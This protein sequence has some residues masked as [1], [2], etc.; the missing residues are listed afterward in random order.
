[1]LADPKDP[2]YLGALVY[3]HHAAESLSFSRAAQILN[4][5][6]SA[7]SH[8]ITA[9][10]NA[11]GKRLFERRVR[12]VRLTQDGAE[13]ARATAVI[14]NELKEITG[15]LT[16]QEVL[17]VSVG[18]YLSS[19]WLL[20]RIGAFEAQ[21]PGLRVDLIHVIGQPDVRLADV[22]ITWAQLDDPATGTTLLFNTKAVP[23]AAPGLNVGEN[24]WE[25]KL[26]PIHYRD[27]TAWRHW[28]SAT[29]AP[30]EYAERGEVL[31][32]PHIVLEAAAFGRGVAIGFLP[33][34]D[35]FFEQG[36][37]VHVGTKSVRSN[38]GY[39]LEVNSDAQPMANLFADWVR[40]RAKEKLS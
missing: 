20:P 39:R 21:H 8:R 22:S 35:K 13:L 25:G 2:S 27:R 19:Q 12:E 4:V 28:L 1:M 17:R 40:S 38:R 36:R 7:V 6:P 18:P 34:V 10:E 26:P 33:F 16:T 30:A 5:T 24:F 14:W 29:G 9:L 32:E 11:I 37:L 23:V 3:F 31:E 15:K